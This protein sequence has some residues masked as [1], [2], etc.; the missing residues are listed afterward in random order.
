MALF[1]ITIYNKD[2]REKVEFGE[3]HG[4][5]RDSWADFQY[6]E[7][8]AIDEEDARAKIEKMHPSTQGFVIDNIRKTGESD[9]VGDERRREH[10]IS[11]EEND[12]RGDGDDRRET[13]YSVN[14]LTT[15]T[16]VDLEKFLGEECTD[17]WR[18][19]FLEMDSQLVEKRIQ[20]MFANESDKENFIVNHSRSKKT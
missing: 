6:V 5:F 1:E 2:V 15:K 3:H 18:I 20:I 11:V 4:R 7:I 14:F 8:A 9:R 19:I 16:L 12:R 10:Q 17:K 13:P